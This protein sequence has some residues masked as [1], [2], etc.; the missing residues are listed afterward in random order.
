VTLARAP[1]PGRLTA[2]G[3]GQRPARDGFRAGPAAW[4]T[5]AAARAAAHGYIMISDSPGPAAAC[6]DESLMTRIE[7][8]HWDSACPAK[9]RKMLAYVGCVFLHKM[10][11][12]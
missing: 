1:G 6:D 3:P 8:S 11:T 4:V 12:T 2:A 7:F 10:K 5:V 9:N